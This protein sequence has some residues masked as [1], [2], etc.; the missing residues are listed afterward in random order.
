MI[1]SFE[2]RHYKSKTT[3]HSGNDWR[4]RCDSY[5]RRRTYGFAS[6]Q[7]NTFIEHN[8]DFRP[9]VHM[10]KRTVV[11]RQSPFLYLKLVKNEFSESLRHPRC[12]PYQRRRSQCRHDDILDLMKNTNAFGLRFVPTIMAHQERYSCKVSGYGIFGIPR[13]RRSKI[14]EQNCRGLFL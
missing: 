11:P 4:R 1:F 7:C 14:F 9:Y 12:S 5:G 10:H 6:W 13:S 8:N 3:D 2:G